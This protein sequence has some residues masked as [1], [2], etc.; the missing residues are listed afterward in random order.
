MASFLSTSTIVGGSFKSG[1]NQKSDK[2]EEIELGTEPDDLDQKFDNKADKDG[3]GGKDSISKDGKGDGKGD[4][5][6]DGNTEDSEESKKEDQDEDKEPKTPGMLFSDSLHSTFPSI[7]YEYSS[8]RRVVELLVD[9]NADPLFRAS[10][11]FAVQSGLDAIKDGLD[12]RT[13]V[14]ESTGGKRAKDQGLD[15]AQGLRQSGGFVSNLRS[16][17][18][19]PVINEMV[20][21]F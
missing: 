13:I 16:N 2:R 20:R 7:I 9:H 6:E 1:F 17:L 18:N 10:A 15:F 21:N 5:K 12:I 4:G 14:E 11:K 8:H 3:K 19:Y